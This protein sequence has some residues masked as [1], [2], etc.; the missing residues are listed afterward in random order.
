[1]DQVQFALWR[2]RNAEGVMKHVVSVGMSE[3]ELN[4]NGTIGG[5]ISEINVGNIQILGSSGIVA[6]DGSETTFS[7]DSFPNRK[8]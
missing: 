2:F 6:T 5:E 3:C 4:V 7:L 1:M 8:P